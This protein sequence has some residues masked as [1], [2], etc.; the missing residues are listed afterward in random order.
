MASLSVCRL[1]LCLLGM[2]SELERMFFAINSSFGAAVLR[3]FKF[4]IVL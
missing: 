1:E 3:V 2:I 4:D